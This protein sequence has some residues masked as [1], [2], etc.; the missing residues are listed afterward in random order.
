MCTVFDAC[1]A[2]TFVATVLACM[3]DLECVDRTVLAVCAVVQIGL[4]LSCVSG[5]TAHVVFVVALS[6]AAIF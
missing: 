5:E 3:R 2:V 4:L 6:Y 1:V